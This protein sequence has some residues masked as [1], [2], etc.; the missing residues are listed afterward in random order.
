MQNSSNNAQ[1]EPPLSPPINEV[2]CSLPE[3]VNAIIKWTYTYNGKPIVIDEISADGTRAKV[4]LADYWIQTWVMLEKGEVK[5]YTY[6]GKPIQINTISADGTNATTWNKIISLKYNIVRL[7]DGGIEPY[8]YDGKPI[9]VEKISEDGKKALFKQSPKTEPSKWALV[10]DGAIRTYL[11]N[12]K[13]TPI[14]EIYAD[15][16]LVRIYNR[17]LRKQCCVIVKNGEILK[18]QDEY[19]VYDIR[20]DQIFYYVWVQEYSCPIPRHIQSILNASA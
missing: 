20:D 17:S 15:E 18:T 9:R 4:N 13:P 5:M 12:G 16:Q 2:T 10:E 14:L 1:V 11:L 6:N 3:Q 7:V 8:R 19:I